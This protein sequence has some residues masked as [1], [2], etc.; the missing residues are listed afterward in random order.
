MQQKLKQ[1][2]HFQGL[3]VVVLLVALTLGQGLPPESWAAARL[4]PVSRDKKFGYMDQTGRMVIHPRFD[5]V[6][7]F[8]EGLAHVLIGGKT[9]YIDE[10]GKMVIPPQF[11][12]ATGFSEGM[13]W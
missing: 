6:G 12:L 10:S 5:G 8:S 3:T 7:E 11:D 9:G 1:G 4:I 2:R 13:P